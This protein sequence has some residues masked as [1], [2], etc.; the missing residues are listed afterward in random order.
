[1]TQSYSQCL[2]QKNDH[3]KFDLIKYYNLKFAAEYQERPRTLNMVDRLML[4]I[5]NIEIN[6]RMGRDMEL[7]YDLCP[8]L[9]TQDTTKFENK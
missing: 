1:M 8:D 7:R 3:L 9:P 5:V 4:R 6:F 2:Y